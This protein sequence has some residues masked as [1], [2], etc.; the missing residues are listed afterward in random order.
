LSGRTIFVSV[1]PVI[2][3]TVVSFTVGVVTTALPVHV[4]VVGRGPAIIIPPAEVLCGRP[5]V[6]LT[7]GRG[8]RAATFFTATRRPGTFTTV[9]VVAPVIPVAVPIVSPLVATVFSARAL[10]E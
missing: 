6:I 5:P 1:V 10:S 9:P 2:T 3:T 4:K 8:T 7:P